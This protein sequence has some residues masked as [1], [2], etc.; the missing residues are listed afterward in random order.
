MK[1]EYW[2]T[3]QILLTSKSYFSFREKNKQVSKG[4]CIRQNSLAFDN[5]L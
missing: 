4:M 5:Y 3:K 1:V 2:G